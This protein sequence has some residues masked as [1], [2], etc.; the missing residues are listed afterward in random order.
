VW[1]CR[2]DDE[3]ADESADADANVRQCVADAEGIAS[4]R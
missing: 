2:V 4:P 1:R 3:S